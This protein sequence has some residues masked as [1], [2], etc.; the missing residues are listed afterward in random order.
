MQSAG[1]IF[2]LVAALM[3]AVAYVFVR[4]FTQR[5]HRGAI[6]LL[7]LGHALIGIVCAVALPFIWSDR[8]ASFSQYAWPLIG[9]C[10]FYL[11]A[12][13]MLFAVLAKTD[14]SR[15]SPLLAMKIVFLTLISV[16]FF[17]TDLNVNQWIG[18]ALA[19]I[20]AFALSYTGGRL[21]WKTAGAVMVMCI[22]Y[23][24]ADLSVA[25]L[26]KSVGPADKTEAVIVSVAIIYTLCGLV[27]MAMLPFIGKGIFDGIR[28][29]LG[30]SVSWLI[31]IVAFFASIAATSVVFCNV[32]QTSRGLM[33]IMLAMLLS[34]MGLVHIE[35]KHKPRV[36]IAQ[37]AAAAMIFLAIALWD[38]WI[39]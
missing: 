36:R 13:A 35:Q 1:I 19:T 12:Q 6:H 10:G 3:Q 20:A 2:G 25:T 28:Y 16:T 18:I 37:T 21:P 33:S 27:A 24:L 29:T 8:I 26:M 23:S 38:G 4:V 39:F 9:S 22:F 32:I 34:S 5:R 15:V 31:C 11:V 14:A 7:I 30:F 17:D